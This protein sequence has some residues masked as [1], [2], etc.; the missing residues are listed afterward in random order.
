ML[1]VVYRARCCFESTGACDEYGDTTSKTQAVDV[2]LPDTAV[3]VK[4]SALR[5]LFAQDSSLWFVAKI[6]EL[7]MWSSLG[8]GTLPYPKRRGE[9]TPPQLSQLA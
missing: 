7:T 5:S 3:I 1:S 9:T 8:S 4:N 2:P 6:V